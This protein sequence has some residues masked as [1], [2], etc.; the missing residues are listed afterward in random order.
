VV[1]EIPL[2]SM[3]RY[4]DLQIFPN[5][6]LAETGEISALQAKKFGFIVFLVFATF[7]SVLSL[8]LLATQKIA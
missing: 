8:R 2:F 3:I 5:L 6:F 7:L 1:A 4:L